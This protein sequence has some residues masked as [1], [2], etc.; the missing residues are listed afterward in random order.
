MSG[1]YGFRN[2]GD[3]LILKAVINDLRFFRPDIEI[4]VLS[5][6][7]AETAKT[8]KVS[9]VNRWNIFSII[10]EILGCR[11]LLSGSGGL[12]QDTTGFLS[13]WYYLLI[14]SIA[15]IFRKKIF[16]YAVGIGGIKHPFN[17]FLIKYC[18]GRADFITVRTIYDKEMLESFGI[19]RDIVVT[20]DPV[21]GLDPTTCLPATT[22]ADVGGSGDTQAGGGVTKKKKIGIIVRK[23][24]SRKNELKIFFQLSKALSEKFNMEVIF[25]PFQ[26]SSDLELLKA[27]KEKSGDTSRIF[28]WENTDE[29]LKLFLQLDAV[30]SM[31]LHGLILAAKYG[32][33]FVPIP[34]YLKIVNFLHLLGEKNIPAISGQT[35]K[36]T[37]ENIYE[38][39]LRKISDK[40]INISRMS[41]ILADLKN[42][43]RKTAELCIS[44]LKENS[45]TTN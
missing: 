1:Y 41:G 17:K 31:R 26:K 22:S 36:I 35:E 2:A 19:K 28:S 44:Q 6:M 7:P 5:A 15:K 34:G 4:T 38:L 45:V 23:T 30:I 39:I 16:I 13:L 9:S 40:E 11:M 8:Y 21:F 43:A 25:I 27:I 37:A 18:F 12:F 42:K 32:I 24:G 33:P 20:A 14:I 3:E 10:P 29:L